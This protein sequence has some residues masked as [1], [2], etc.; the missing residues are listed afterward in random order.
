M[1]GFKESVET[2]SEIRVDPQPSGL[3]AVY[4][5]ETRSSDEVR[6]IQNLFLE[7]EV[8]MQVKQLS[9]G[10]LLSYTVQADGSDAALLDEVDDILKANYGFVVMHRSFD[11][12]I[13][14]I[15]KELSNDTD[16][17][18]LPL[19]HCNICG[20]VEPFPNTVISL[21]D[22]DGEVRLSRAYCGK[23]TA[24][25]AAPSNKE[26]VRLLLSADKRDFSILERAELVRHPSRKRPIRFRV[27]AGERVAV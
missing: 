11:D 1:P 6:D 21:T 10:K 18:V 12:L 3:R 9:K 24:E 2:I 27:Q 4:M 22:E 5:I 23:C 8:R 20:K 14:R 25:A 13:Y 26:F 15:V 17:K 16:S 19:P 7:L